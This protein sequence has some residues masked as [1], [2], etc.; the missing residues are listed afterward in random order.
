MKFGSIDCFDSFCKL[1][2]SFASVSSRFSSRRA[3][4]D[5]FFG[6]MFFVL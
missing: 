3:R 5:N 1:V 4:I 2:A 6:N